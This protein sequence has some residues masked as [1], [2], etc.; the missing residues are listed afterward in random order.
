MKR[1]GF[2]KI[3][4]KVFILI[5]IMKM[6]LHEIDPFTKINFIRWI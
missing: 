3:L 4:E 6:F 2:D 1:N 5:S